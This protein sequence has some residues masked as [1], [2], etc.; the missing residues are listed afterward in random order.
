M[1]SSD[2]QLSRRLER[3]E[4]HA[5]AEFAQA[6]RRLFPDSGAEYIEC[7]GAYVV[8]D[9]IASPV[10]QG[11]GLGIFEDLTAATLDTIERFFFDRGASVNLEISPFAGVAAL[12]LLCA[13]NYRPIEVSNVL[14]RSTEKLAAKPQSNINVRII[15]PGESELWAQINTRGWTHDYPDLHDFLSQTSAISSNRDHNLLFLAEIDG[16]PGAAGTLSVHKGVALF[17]GAATVPELRGRG[18]QTALLQERMRH[19]FEH[20]CDLAMMV[21]EPGTRSQR[22]AER[23]GFHIV[24][25]R[26]KWQLTQQAQSSPG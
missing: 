21:A 14:C 26:T 7:A 18:L 17:A 23:A 6:R 20:G 4:G 12:D 9:G 10:T 5:C 24:Y 1:L 3:A 22:N 25:T 8:F 2:L 19:A 13:R 15:G 16:Q 11:F